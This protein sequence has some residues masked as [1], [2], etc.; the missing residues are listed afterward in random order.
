[1]GHA[2]T[3]ARYGVEGAMADGSC[4]FL[5]A[6][7]SG[8]ADRPER[9]GKPDGTTTPREE[10]EGAGPGSARGRWVQKGASC[11]RMSSKAA[12]FARSGEGREGRGRVGGA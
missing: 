3:W 8:G 4:S 12:E 2:F 11:G 9:G 10:W 7:G 1:M 5:R 6:D